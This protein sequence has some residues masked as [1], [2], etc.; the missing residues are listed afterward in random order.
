M[1]SVK[2]FL[3]LAFAVV[4]TACATESAP[5]GGDLATSGGPA[6]GE[7]LFLQPM[8]GTQP[9]CVTCHSLQAGLTLVGPSLAN[10][11]TEAGSAVPGQ[12]AQEYL[13][14]AIVAPDEHVVAGFGAGIM[15]AL[16]GSELSDQ[17]IQDLVAYLLT[18]R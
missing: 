11:G 10:A 2:L 3:L 9:G 7:A 14:Q 8:I 13:R 5:R 12:A 6:S 17:Q 1:R 15:P 16:Y 18:L 4:V